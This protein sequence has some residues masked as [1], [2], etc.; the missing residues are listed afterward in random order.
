MQLCKLCRDM[1]DLPGD[2][3][4]IVIDEWPEM[5]GWMKGGMG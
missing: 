4:P 5:I 1:S 2:L 3:G